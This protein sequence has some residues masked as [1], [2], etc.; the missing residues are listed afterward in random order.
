MANL[1]EL[2][3][4]D[5]GVYQIETTDPVL[6]GPDGTANAQGK[7]LANRT[8]WLKDQVEALGDGKQPLDA[9]LTAIAGLVGAADKMPYFNG[10]DTAALATL[11]AFART[12][13]DD[14]DAASA[15]G[16]LGVD[17]A[18]ST[19][20]AALVDS[21]PATLDTLNELA[22]ALGDDPS[23]ATTVMNA[24]AAKAGLASPAFTGEP[25]AP[26]PALFDNGTSLAT[27][28][29]VQRSLG[30]R[31]GADGLSS[32]ATLTAGHAG[33]LIQVGSAGGYTITLPLLS[34]LQSGATIEFVSSAA[35]L[36]TIQRQGSDNIHPLMG[37]PIS[38][39][40]LANG[41][42]ATLVNANGVWGL[43]GGTATLG[44]AR[45]FDCRAWVNFNGTGTVAIRASGNV[46]SITDNGTGDY[47]VNFTT[48]MP[49]ANYAVN[50][51][52]TF[53]LTGIADYD[54]RA[55]VAG[56]NYFLTGSIRVVFS[57]TTGDAIT[58][59]PYAMLVTI[60]R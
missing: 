60:F 10:A 2:S 51:T 32:G 36:V 58:G 5:A 11:T 45:R 41:D 48:A 33:K 31:C 29:F 20:I 52:G 35:A 42:T 46:S 21:S 22:A 53:W 15:R 49:D 56:T 18:I 37:A 28:A 9:T 16:T 40:T 27:T 50:V 59:D 39:F 13:L 19:A 43:V 4:Y 8:K 25:T 38:S 24:I 47:T 44:Y 26:T 30:N 1:T 54:Y 55:T 14:A 17:T 7:A 12:L 6:G 23:F 57:K 34:T 3:Q